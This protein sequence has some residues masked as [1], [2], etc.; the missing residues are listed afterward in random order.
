MQ[1][2]KPSELIVIDDTDEKD[3]KDVRELPATRAALMMCDAYGIEWKYQ[4]GHKRGQH[5]SHQMSQNI[6][7]HDWIWRVDDDECPVTT[8]LENLCNVVDYPDHWKGEEVGA[9]GGCVWI[10]M[11]ADRPDNAANKIEDLNLPNLQWF[12]PVEG[13]V[14]HWIPVEVDHLHS[15]FLYRKNKVNYEMGLSP[16]AHR[17]ETMFTY[18]LKRAGYKIIFNPAALTWHFRAATGGI[19]SHDQIM[20][21]N[22]DEALFNHKLVQWGVRREPSTLLILDAGL[23]DHVIARSLVPELKRRYPKL[24]LG[25]TFPDIFADTGI[26]LT[27][28][29]DAKLRLG[30]DGANMGNV[31]MW[32]IAHGWT[33]TLREAYK[34]MWKL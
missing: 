3:I 19:R 31:Y 5:I 24:E 11:P 28:I 16:A 27:S 14:D 15:T 6:A 26:K 17:E 1:T 7:K 34:E 29:A 20:F 23:G 22:S 8:C 10:P 2:M 4:Y 32:M 30:E 21:W 33:K 18:E 9:V 12:R 13:L 25:V